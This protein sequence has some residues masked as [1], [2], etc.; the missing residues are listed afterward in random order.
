MKK[1]LLAIAS[2]IA[3]SGCATRQAN[4]TATNEPTKSKS[5]VVYYSQTGTTSQL[6]NL[7]SSRL[8]IDIDSIVCN[9][10][11]N[12]DFGQTIERCKNDM[13]NGTVPAVKPLSHNLAEY[14]TIYLGY[15]V[16]FGTFAPPVSSFVK[17]NDLKGKVL[18]P[19]CTFGSGGLN[20]STDNLKALLPDTK[21]AA[22]YGVR[23]ARIAKAKNELETFLVVNGIVKGEKVTL[24][25]F[26]AQEPINDEYKKIFDAA[27]G[28]YQMPLGTPITVGKRDIKNGTEYKFTVENK[29]QDGKVSQSIIYV[30]AEN[31]VE[32]E[33]TQVVR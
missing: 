9:E 7:I 27:C 28:N 20:T 2:A 10:P 18:I 4:N 17:N 5:I 33:F 30:T 11:Y 25:E 3:I 23:S 22:G 32:P 1:T 13:Q 31:G 24:P 16:W 8:S 12:G 21:I 14:D 6:A 29:D 15:P 26:S 19:F